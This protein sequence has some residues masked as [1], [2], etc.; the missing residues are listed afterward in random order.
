MRGE[1]GRSAV[2]HGP[3]DCAAQQASPKR[4]HPFRAVRTPKQDAVA[5]ADS[6]L[7]QIV[8]EPGGNPG[9]PRIVPGFAPVPAALDCGDVAPV[10]A[11]IIE[12]REE[13]WSRHW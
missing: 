2:L 5:G 3:G 8:R 10:A 11:E 9:Q 12:E 13:G 7:F 6:A 1:V 4:S